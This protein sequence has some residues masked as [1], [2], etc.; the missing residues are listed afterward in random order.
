MTQEE[1]CEIL[2]EKGYT[3]DPET[4]NIYSRLGKI[5]K[6]KNKGYVHIGTTINKKTLNLFGHN[7]AWYCVYGNCDTDQI[8]H[9][10]GVRDDNRICNL[11]NV[12]KNQNQWNRKT[13]K[14]YNFYRNKYQAQIQVNNKRIYLGYFTT[15]QE[16]RQ[17][18][19]NAKEKYHII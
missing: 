10:N 7:F 15:E 12:N 1:R 4:G 11:R 9:I 18:Y 2:I 16:A 19:L 14:G 6:R 13:A 8:D 3:Y 17:A 5:L